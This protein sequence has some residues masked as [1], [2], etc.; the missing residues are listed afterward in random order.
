MTAGMST[1]PWLAHYDSDVPQTIACYPGKTLVDYLAEL[2][3]ERADNPVILFKGSTMTYRRLEAESNA[4]AAALV[5]MGVHPGDRVALLLPNCPQFMVAE[6]GIWKAGGIVVAL[7]PTYSEREIET[8]LDSTR[9]STVVTL[10]PFYKRVKNVQGRT[11]VRSV[12]AT[13]IKEYLPP[14]LRVLF[15][16][17]K[18]KKDGHRISLSHGDFRFQD[19]LRRQRASARPALTVKPDDRAVILSSGGTTGTPKGVV[20]LHRHYVAA[21]LQIYEWTKSAKERWLD[22]IMVPL[23]LFHVYANLGL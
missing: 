4:F 7:N 3:R 21:G 14:A 22:V 5:A 16:L 15:T 10:T 1:K 2:A 19:L 9:A 17:F 12:V 23:P 13:S 11:Q 20:G 18:E 6:F 8:A